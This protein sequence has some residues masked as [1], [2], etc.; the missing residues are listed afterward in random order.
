MLARRREP[1][2]FC[3]D[4]SEQR[5]HLAG[6]LGAALFE[7]MVAAGWVR[8]T[9]HRR[10]VEVTAAGERGLR[11]RLGVEPVLPQPRRLAV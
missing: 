3:V 1:L 7:A 10:A 8:R 9:P 6:G 5:H 2:R 11:E 4:W